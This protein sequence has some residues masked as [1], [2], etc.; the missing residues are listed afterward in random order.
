MGADMEDFE[1][2]TL[3][4]DARLGTLAD[5]TLLSDRY[6]VISRIAEGGMATVFLADDV[7]HGRR[8]AIKVLHEALAHTIGI[9][10][11]LREIDVVARLQHPHLLTLIDSGTVGGFPYYVMPFVESQSLRQTIAERGQLSLNDAVAI[12][13]EI[14]DG[15]AYA[16]SHG[17]VHRDI[18]PSNVL[19]S[20]GHAI[21]ADFGIATAVRNSAVSRITVTGSSLGSPTYMSPEQAAG[22]ADIDERS[23]IYSVACVLYEMLT[24]QAPIDNVSMQAMVTRKLTGGYT[25]LRELRPDLPVSIETAVHRALTPDRVERFTTMEEFSRA[26]ALAIPTTPALSRRARWTAA[27]AL[28][29]VVGA[30][31]AFVQHQRKVVWA[32]QKV[33][34]ITRLVRAGKFHDAFQL[35]Q[36]VLPI[37]P[38]DSTLKELRPLFTDFLKVAT[39][40]PGA[41]VSIRRLGQR[42]SAWTTVGRTPL[43]SLPMPKPITEMGYEMRLE[44]AGYEPVTVHAMLFSL[45]FP[46]VGP[47]TITLDPVGQPTAGMARIHGGLLIA[48]DG[49]RVR[50]GDFHIGRFEVTN[51]EYMRFVAAGGYGKREYWT[52]PMVRGGKPVSWDDGVATLV[53]QTGQPGP[54]TWSAGTFPTG[55]A[56][57]P[58]GGLSYYEAAAYARFAGMQLPTAEHWRV[59][60][61][62]N[63]REALFMYA[64]SAN[65][66]GKGPRAVG[67]GIPNVYGLYDVG[68]NVR[69]WCVNPIGLGHLTR[70][71]MWSDDIYHM[72]HMI[73]SEDFD[74]APGNGLRL[75]KLTDT[76]STLSRFTGRIER[77]A[78][79]DFNA[80]VPASKAEYEGYRHIYDYDAHPLET[81]LEA[82]GE[83]ETI[84]WQKV[85]FTAA[86]DGP[87]MAA[88]L[89][90]PRHVSPPYVPII[91][92]PPANAM[93]ERVFNPRQ[94]FLDALTGFIPGVDAYS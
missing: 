53:D 52:E 35:T 78:P 42:D 51:R 72:G 86:Y 84:R 37:I 54:S 31:T 49:K 61:F 16:H 82:E 25:P 8:V 43:D 58:V 69:E 89:L 62:R 38:N 70:G 68:G 36:P 74:R 22:E 21:I 3:S 32:S 50:A 15:L 2:P 29:V 75:A 14:A 7:K 23:D 20:D 93:S 81:K 13:R 71:G 6:R 5:G 85:S 87:R 27:A 76:D 17:V 80:V 44:H 10:R 65:M 57:F 67:Q 12:A 90:I 28:F 63:N 73:G 94:P 92:W 45:G 18:K 88:Y 48:T 79:R 11:F 64:P 34:E 33:G 26:I 47:D 41:T 24:G 66:N 91:V 46:G 77:S 19:M 39:Q 1:P 59:A 4:T 9:Q 83:T 40:P 60:A 30:G 56:D 55:E